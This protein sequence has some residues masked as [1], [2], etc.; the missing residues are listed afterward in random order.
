MNTN[1]LLERITQTPDMLGGKPCVR[2]YRLSVEQV[3]DMLIAGAHSS[4]LCKA[5]P[6]LEEADV[7]ACLLYARQ[8]L[9]SP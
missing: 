9:S 8:H 5:Y 3:L 2:G 4:T 6:W 7:Q 1:T